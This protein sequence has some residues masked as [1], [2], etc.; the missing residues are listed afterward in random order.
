[1][2]CS[3]KN[4]VAVGKQFTTPI[5]GHFIKK[6]NPDSG[7]RRKKKDLVRHNETLLRS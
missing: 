4:N 7:W 2:P 1:M 5:Y 3:A 6:T